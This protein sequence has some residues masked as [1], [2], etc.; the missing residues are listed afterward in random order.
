MTQS[1][2]RTAGFSFVELL[3]SI[4]IAGVAF[5]ALVPLFV[6]AQS[7]Q[8]VD[9][10]RVTAL[11]VA[12]DRIEK[13]RQLDYDLITT[14]NLAMTTNSGDWLYAA[15]FGPSF[16][17]ARG[18]V[19]DVAYDVIE[20]QDDGGKVLYKRVTVRVDWTSPPDRVR[21]SNGATGVE[22]RT[23]STSPSCRRRSCLRPPRTPRPPHSS[24]SGTRPPKAS[25]R[26]ASPRLSTRPTPPT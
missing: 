1:P 19:Y 20:V 16:T 22:L 12:Q 21:A 23:S 6:Q 18:R 4:L 10:V 3:V 8:S 24:S 5:A 15:E 2:H 13:V 11:N 9:K 25:S 26:C 7:Q 14:E 17:T